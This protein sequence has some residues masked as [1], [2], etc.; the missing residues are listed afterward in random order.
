[1]RRSLE[2]RPNALTWLIFPQLRA[3]YT[4][5]EPGYYVVLAEFSELYGPMPIKTIPDGLDENTSEDINDF[6]VQIMSID[7]T[8]THAGVPSYSPADTSLIYQHTKS[9]VSA[10]IHFFNLHDVHARGN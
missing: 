7:Y 4:S 8:G 5:R 3:R 2:K 9:K 10:F 1:M 6:I